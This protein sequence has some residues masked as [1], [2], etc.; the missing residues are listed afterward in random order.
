M[1]TYVTIPDADINPDKP[2]KS[3]TAYALRN[4]LLAVV[5][6]DSTAPSVQPAILLIGGKGGD[7]E[8]GRASCRERV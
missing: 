5:E 3:A 6:G 7:G 8:I 4:N 2:I 1:T